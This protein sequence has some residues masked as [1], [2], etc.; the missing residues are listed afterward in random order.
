MTLRSS[1]DKLPFTCIFRVRSEESS[2]KESTDPFSETKSESFKQNNWWFKNIKFLTAVKKRQ[3]WFFFHEIINVERISWSCLKIEQNFMKTFESTGSKL[4]GLCS[5]NSS[6]YQ[7]QNNSN[8]P[9]RRK[10]RFLEVVL[11]NLGFF[12]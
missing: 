2:L 10:N 3:I 12:C 11:T 8:F 1:H 4:M 9:M 5:E 6:E 7:L